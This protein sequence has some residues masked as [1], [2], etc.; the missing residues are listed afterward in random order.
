MAH[1]IRDKKNLLNRVRRIR[2]EKGSELFSPCQ[3]RAGVVR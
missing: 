1:T 2:A 3:G